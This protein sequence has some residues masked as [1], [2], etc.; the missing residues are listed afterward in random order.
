MLAFFLSQLKMQDTLLHKVNGILILVTFFLC[1]ILLFPFMYAALHH[2]CSVWLPSPAGTYKL[3]R[4]PPFSGHSIKLSSQVLPTASCTSL[5]FPLF[6][7]S[8]MH[9]QLIDQHPLCAFHS[10]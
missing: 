4:S 5:E 10:V 9:Q 7:G 3:D 1:R 8:Q 6:Q 2:D